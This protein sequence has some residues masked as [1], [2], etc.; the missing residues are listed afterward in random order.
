[1]NASRV[2]G[3]AIGGLL[4][5]LVGASGVFL[6]N[7]A[8]YLLVIATILAVRLPAPLP[9]A[10]RGLRRLTAGF[11]TAREDSFVGGTLVLLFAFSLL[12][13]PIVYQFP[14]LAAD[15]LGMDVTSLAYG[16]LYAAFG[17]GALLGALAVGTVL[18]HADRLTVVRRG[19]VGH[20]LC[21]GVLAL[22]RTSAPAYPVALALGACYF[23]TVTSLNT[24]LQTHLQP[25][26]RGRVMG[27]WIMAFGGSVPLGLLLAGAVAERTSISVVLAYGAVAALVLAWRS[28]RLRR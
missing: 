10:E 6:V 14:T 7:A 2:L 4:Y 9:S 27:L 3:P 1:M 26:V 28:G 19:L 11:R 25:A 17:T 24:L 15:D 8:S 20:A 18:A 22:L 23:A 13:L 5:P 16:L 12:S 21:L